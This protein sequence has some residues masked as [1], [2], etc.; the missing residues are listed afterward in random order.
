MCTLTYGLVVA[1]SAVRDVLNSTIFSIS[2]ASLD[3][4]CPCLMM[5][6]VTIVCSGLDVLDFASDYGS[7]PGLVFSSCMHQIRK[8][9][10]TLNTLNLKRTVILVYVII[11]GEGIPYLDYF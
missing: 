7:Y 8:R 6:D 4:W 11:A 5:C 2:V 9:I 1:V 3:G 10:R